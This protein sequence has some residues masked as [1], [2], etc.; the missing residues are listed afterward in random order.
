MGNGDLEGSEQRLSVP[1]VEM[2]AKSRRAGAGGGWLGSE[3]GGD[4]AERGTPTPALP[5]FP[6]PRGYANANASCGLRR[7]RGAPRP[8]PGLGT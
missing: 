3:C 5:G 6:S 2:S 1:G 7:H 8:A 4:N